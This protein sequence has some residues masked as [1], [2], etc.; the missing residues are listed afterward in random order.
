MTLEIS[1]HTLIGHIITT[2]NIIVDVVYEPHLISVYQVQVFL[3]NIEAAAHYP[4]HIVV[5]LQPLYILR[6]I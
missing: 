5:I 4:I 3:Q 6:Q 1:T 2:L